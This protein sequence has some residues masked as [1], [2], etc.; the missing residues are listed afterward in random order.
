MEMHVIRPAI[1]ESD[2]LELRG[3][4]ETIADIDEIQ[5]PMTS[6]TSAVVSKAQCSLQSVQKKNR[7]ADH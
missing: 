4:L 6:S 2:A 1:S 7:A 5:P 3:T